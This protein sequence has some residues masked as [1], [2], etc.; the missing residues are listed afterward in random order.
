[1][2][3]LKNMLNIH[4]KTIKHKDQRYETIGDWVW[5]PNG[6]LDIT[7]SDL[8]DTYKETLVAIHE[9]V[10]VMLCRLRG[11]SQEEVDNFDM[12]YEARRSPEDTTSEPGDS[13]LAP[14]K[15][16]HRFAT[17]IEQAICHE[18]GIDWKEYEKTI[19]SL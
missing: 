2:V 4:I 9:L 12:E 1:M 14:Y 6:R 16:E 7:I 5:Q 19:Y 15:D 13:A 10:E 17:I 3:P 11:I 8:G 18:M